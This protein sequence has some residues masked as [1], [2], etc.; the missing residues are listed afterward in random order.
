M[1]ADGP[2][3]YDWLNQPHVAQRWGGPITREEVQ[4]HY[5]DV[6]DS[7]T[8]RFIACLDGKPLGYIQT[9]WAT[10]VGG[11]WWPNETDPGTIGIDFFIGDAGQLDRGIGSAMLRQF[12]SDL[13]RK[14]RVT[15][16]I[17]DPS[18]ENPRSIKC[19]SNAG[20]TNLGIIN[21]PDGAAVLM[22]LSI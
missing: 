20:F 3:L 8:E 2:L 15:K 22:K 16:V 9:Y 13:L 11:G 17:S 5:L 6:L 10:E 21:T 14:P 4:E 18:P 1:P 19:L 7:S 12:T